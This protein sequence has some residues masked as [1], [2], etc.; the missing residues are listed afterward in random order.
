MRTFIISCMVFLVFGAITAQT[1]AQQS[2]PQPMVAVDSASSLP[3]VAV[4]QPPMQVLGTQT[5]VEP[6]VPS[7]SVGRA[8]PS[9][10]SRLA[11]SN[12]LI[13][14]GEKATTQVVSELAEDMAVMSRIFGN[15]L[16]ETLNM[17][18]GMERNYDMYP[19]LFNQSRVEITQ[20]IYISGFGAIFTLKTNFPMVPP[21][22]VEQKEPESKDAV[23]RDTKEELLYG[24]TSNSNED[25]RPQY[26]AQK[27]ER[28]RTALLTTLKHASN[29]RHIGADELVTVVIN[30]PG[31]APTGEFAKGKGDV[32]V[33]TK[34][35]KSSKTVRLLTKTV[36]ETNVLT[37]RAKKSDV[38]DF[39]NEKIDYDRFSEKIKVV[40]F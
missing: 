17:P 32:T 3:P 27:A 40:T 29:I 35:D 12:M 11:S 19:G 15:K 22:K 39:A 5:H 18:Y 21:P 25:D 30:A 6:T 2:V 36:A 4:A 9:L 26:D 38:D 1:Y 33:V 7:V 24:K 34:V 31:P 37:I 13:I 23:W 16:N 28:L 8:I 14:P 10:N 20:T